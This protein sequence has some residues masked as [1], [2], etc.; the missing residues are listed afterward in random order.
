MFVLF[1]L[2]ADQAGNNGE[3]ADTSFHITGSQQPH[4]LSSSLRR[5]VRIQELQSC[6]NTEIISDYMMNAEDSSLITKPNSHQTENS[7][8][9]GDCSDGL[10]SIVSKN[11]E[12]DDPEQ[13][14]CDN[15]SNFTSDVCEASR[16]TTNVCNIP[17]KKLKSADD[18]SNVDSPFVMFRKKQQTE[19]PVSLSQNTGT[20]SPRR[21]SLR[22]VR[23]QDDFQLS[24]LV[25]DVSKE[26]LSPKLPRR[27]PLKKVNKKENEQS[28]ENVIHGTL[29]QSD[30]CFDFSTSCDVNKVDQSTDY[31]SSVAEGNDDSESI[32]NVS[33]TLVEDTQSPY[34]LKPPVQETSHVITETPVKSDS[35]TSPPFRVASARKLFAD[36]DSAS[37][38]QTTKANSDQTVES[39]VQNN[40]KPLSENVEMPS[41]QG[42]DIVCDKSTHNEDEIVLQT[43]SNV[44]DKECIEDVPCTSDVHS[45][46]LP[47]SENLFSGTEVSSV[48]IDMMMQTLATALD[49]LQAASEVSNSNESNKTSSTSTDESLQKETASSESDFVCLQPT[50][51]EDV[52]ACTPNKRKLGTPK[53]LSLT[54]GNRMVKRHRKVKESQ[55]SKSVK[56]ANHSK[57]QSAKTD[58]PASITCQDSGA[59][60]ELHS[61]V[62]D[63]F[64]SD[65]LISVEDSEEVFSKV[66]VCGR[67]LQEIGEI[68]PDM[69]SPTSNPERR[70]SAVK[71][72][73]KTQKRKLE[74]SSI[75]KSLAPNKM[76]K[77]ESVDSDNS[78]S[79]CE[80]TKNLSSDGTVWKNKVKLDSPVDKKKSVR[81]NFSKLGKRKYSKLDDLLGDSGSSP[82][83]ET[84]PQVDTSKH[85]DDEDELPLSYLKKSKE[86]KC[87]DSNRDNKNKDVTKFTDEVDTQ[88]SDTNAHPVDYSEKDM[89]D[90]TVNRT[91]QRAVIDTHE[92]DTQESDTDAC[93]VDYSEK[94]VID[95]KVN[96]GT[97]QAQIEFPMLIDNENV[98]TSLCIEKDSI[99]ECSSS[100]SPS[101]VSQELP[102]TGQLVINSEGEPEEPEKSKNMPVVDNLICVET[103]DEEGNSL[104]DVDLV[105]SEDLKPENAVVFTDPETEMEVTLAEIR[106]TN[107]EEEMSELQDTTKV[108][109][110][111][112]DPDQ[113]DTAGISR[114]PDSDPQI[115]PASQRSPPKSACVYDWSPNRSPSCSILKKSTETPP[116]GKVSYSLSVRSKG[117]FSCWIVFF[118][119]CYLICM[120]VLCMHYEFLH[121]I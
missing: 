89:I 78:N 116:G 23:S 98:L 73:G 62:D 20:T 28:S 24:K 61:S 84:K 97:Q 107:P 52:P 38:A 67:A 91:I 92:V 14:S 58:I 51:A 33:C 47:G 21:I 31:F 40:E 9:K 66:E 105:S 119:L 41:S 10:I 93:P 18:Q 63:V 36:G 37:M 53:K 94:D 26:A 113:E 71:R 2:K 27:V 109:A 30:D 45:V 100:A 82:I 11:A 32:V 25:K 69:K 16:D 117:V 106:Q 86:N 34:K 118:Q 72:M 3:C 8:T 81:S 57:R 49:N 22:K 6:S 111:S 83:N 74:N 96:K 70:H 50:L 85:S 88:E 48:A 87:A 76:R 110:D 19:C 104:E 17:M 60:T 59:I 35:S 79:A 101:C 1:Q 64:V 99:V 13:H 80:M 4:A 120:S 65:S 12:K 42:F 46:T 55:C 108:C 121:V 77:L 39:K 103:V 102:Q 114:E 115:R 56:V 112:L 90:T 5:S 44:D 7:Y 95:A 75:S 43:S 68:T 15:V 54:K 29:P